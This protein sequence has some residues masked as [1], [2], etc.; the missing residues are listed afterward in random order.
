ME[1]RRRQAAPDHPGL[2]GAPAAAD[3]RLPR[4]SQRRRRAAAAAARAGLP[5]P[6]AAAAAVPQGG[7]VLRE[8]QWRPAAE[9]ARVEIEEAAAAARRHRRAAAAPAR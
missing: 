4:A 6:A 9:G 2:P 5:A 8:A 7:G 1:G 3:T